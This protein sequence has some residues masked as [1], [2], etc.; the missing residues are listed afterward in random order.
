MSKTAS[1]RAVRSAFSTA[2]ASSSSATYRSGRSDEHAPPLHTGD[3]VRLLRRGGG[4]PFHCGDVRPEPPRDPRRHDRA[5]PV[6]Q[7]T[8][9]RHGGREDIERGTTVVEGG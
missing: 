1:T 5:V 9:V 6:R 3:R 7:S 2:L 8:P 4:A